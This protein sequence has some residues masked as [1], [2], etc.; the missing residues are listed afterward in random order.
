MSQVIV[1]LTACAPSTNPACADR[2]TRRPTTNAANEALR[3]M[4]IVAEVTG[5]RST[6]RLRPMKLGHPIRGTDKNMVHGKILARRK[7]TVVMTIRKL[8]F[9]LVDPLGRHQGIGFNT[10]QH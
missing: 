6:P 8:I 10:A 9:V 7:N 2:L 3:K 5:Q 4:G 1:R